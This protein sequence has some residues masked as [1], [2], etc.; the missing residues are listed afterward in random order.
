MTMLAEVNKELLHDFI[1]ESK[2]ALGTVA[3]LLVRLESAPSDLK[4]VESIFRPVHSM[5]GNAAYFGLMRVKELAH[6][7][8]NILDLVRKGRRGVDRSLGSL[9]LKGVDALNSILDRVRTELREVED[10][11]DFLPLLVDLEAESERSGEDPAPERLSDAP[12]LRVPETPEPDA[13]PAPRKD[14]SRTMR[15][16]EENV[17]RFLDQ[18]GELMGLEE[19][20]RY[21]GKRMAEAGI[22]DELS[23]DMRQAVE[24][25]GHLSSKLSKDVM[26]LRR[27]EAR[28]LLQKAPRLARD[29]AGI[30][31][32]RIDIRTAGEETRIDKSYLELLDA[33]LMHMVRN[34][35]DH[36]IE[37]PAQRAAAGKPEVGTIEVS[38]LELEDSFV[39]RVRDDGRGL[40]MEGLR[41]KAVELGIVR[42]E[43]PFAEAEAVAVLFHSGVSTAREVTEISGRGVGMDVV[44]REIEGTGGRIEVSSASGKGCVFEVRL[45]RS[46]TTRISDGF[47]FRCGEERFVLPMRT[48]VET[49]LVSAASTAKVAGGG[50]VVRFRDDLLRMVDAAEMFDTSP[51]LEE[52][53]VFVRL[54]AKDR[55]CVLRVDE[56]LGVQRTVVKPVERFCDGNGLFAGAAML[57]DGR[58]AMVLSEEGLAEW[59]GR[60]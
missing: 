23:A 40:D 50:T 36:G 27:T 46:I 7:M 21:L 26:E 9:L 31:G 22:P 3:G 60:G 51:S 16:S 56:A 29:V 25:F 35:C 20:F 59:L 57:G 47:L 10:E 33:P 41:R 8:E 14:P 11:D 39:L 49:F 55:S 43:A 19:L 42:A 38:V 4:L 45:P 5:K 2:E 37:T 6:R 53:G 1:D 34:A 48:V 28:P 15:I 30:T 52:G 18:V 12:F 13:A 58:L 54:R 32:K 44:K 17:D 24:Q